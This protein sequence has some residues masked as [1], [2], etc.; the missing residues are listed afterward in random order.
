M[1]PLVIDELRALTEG[2]LT[3]VTLVGLFFT[4]QPLVLDKVST[5]PEGF[6]TVTT[7]MQFFPNRN[8][9]IFFSY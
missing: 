3:L 1:H 8:F 5:V 4:V 7:I 6:P 9:L 2:F